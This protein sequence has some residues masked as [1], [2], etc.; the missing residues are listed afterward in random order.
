[1]EDVIQMTDEI[2]QKDPDFKNASINDEDNDP[3]WIQ[4]CLNGAGK[5]YNHDLKLYFA[6]LLAGEIKNPG[7][8]SKRAIN[9]MRSISQKDA[10]KI[11]NMC[12]YVMYDFNT[13]EAFIL[14]YKNAEYSFKDTSF[15]M[16]L[17][18]LNTSNLVVKQFRAE[19]PYNQG[20]F[21]HKDVGYLI[22]IKAKEYNLPIFSFSELG[23]E[24]LSI[25]DDVE[26]NIDYLKNYTKSITNNRADI[27]VVGGQYELDGELIHFQNNTMYFEIPQKDKGTRGQVHVPQQ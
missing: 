20:F 25:I 1:M 19:Q 22:D 26:V 21:F 17:R 2:L 6:K 24:I 16:E 15:L 13:D 4:E 7:K 5:T 10:E 14:R 3:E 27:F 23:K 11:R 12:Q 8:Y 9:F 18:L